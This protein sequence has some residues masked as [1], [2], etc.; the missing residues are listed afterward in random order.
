MTIEDFISKV[1]CLAVPVITYNMI[2]DHAYLEP[3]IVKNCAMFIA[4]F[5]GAKV[6]SPTA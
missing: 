2:P 3:E 6:T 5:Y 4:S 1:R